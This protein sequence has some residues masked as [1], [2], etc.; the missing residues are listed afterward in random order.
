[1][2]G[3][4]RTFVN[5][6]EEVGCLPLLYFTLLYFTLLYFTLLYLTLLYFILLYFTLLFPYHFVLRYVMLRD[7]VTTMRTGTE[8]GEFINLDS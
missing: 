2:S 5:E 6:M 4:F 1:M 7:H 3:D 8:R